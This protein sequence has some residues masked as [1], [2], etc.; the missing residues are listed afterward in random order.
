MEKVGFVG[1]G[2]M[3][4]RMVERLIAKGYAVIGYNRTKQ[5][6][7]WLVPKG[8]IL[9][10]SPREVA[11]RS[12]IVFSMVTD[13]EAVEDITQG[14]DGIIAG[15]SA[16][17]IYVDMSTIDPAYSRTLAQQ[18]K[19]AGATMLDAPVSGSVV[20]LAEGKLSVMVGGERD[21]IQVKSMPIKPL[22]LLATSHWSSSRCLW[23]NISPAHQP[24][25]PVA[26]IAST[27]S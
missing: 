1:L 13:T 26:L 2:A 15:M 17:K 5:K 8:L 19:S 10:D 20:T 12:D 24:S 21:A 4:G 14:K 23:L 22:M 25:N 9:V 18:V 11:E 3:G 6:A 16:G 27:H 7:G